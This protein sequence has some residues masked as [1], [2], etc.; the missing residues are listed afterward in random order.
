MKS[1]KPGE[2]PKKR[3]MSMSKSKDIV[4]EKKLDARKKQILLLKL[5]WEN[6][7]VNLAVLLAPVRPYFNTVICVK[8]KVGSYKTY[9]LGRYYINQVSK[10]SQ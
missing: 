8:Y 3:S 9:A 2:I 6:A 1:K 10:I 7:L 5:N 4:N